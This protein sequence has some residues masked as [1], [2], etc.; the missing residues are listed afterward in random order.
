MNG[1]QCMSAFSLSFSGSIPESYDKFIFPLN[2]KPFAEAMAERIAQLNPKSVLETA[3]GTGA[4]TA[5]LLSLVPDNIQFTLTDISGAMLELA[6]QKLNAHPQVSFDLIDA[7]SLPYPDN[8]FDLQFSM[9]GLMFYADQIQAL[10]EARRVLKPGGTMLTAVWDALEYNTLHD[11]FYSRLE[12]F[13][14]S[15]HCGF[16]DVPHNC[17]NLNNLKL[18]IEKAGFTDFSIH[19]VRRTIG[20]VPALDA[21]KGYVL[22]TPLYNEFVELGMN[23][24]EVA[25]T[26]S[27]DLSATYGDTLTGFL[28]QAIF[29]EARR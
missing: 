18:M 12:K 16:K 10:S 5:H 2:I 7:S 23:P 3:T 22:G 19:V 14:G 1:T 29:I 17:A 11:A 15:Y 28:R 27:T 20:P 4:C 21:C 9:F 8:H 25:D 6:Q 24:E 26:I 13:Y